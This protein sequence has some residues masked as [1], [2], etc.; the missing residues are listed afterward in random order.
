MKRKDFLKTLSFGTAVLYAPSGLVAQTEKVAPLDKLLVQ[1]FVGAG[2]NNLDKVK[3]LYEEQPALV[4][5]AHDLGGGDFETAIEGAGHVG[6]KEIAQFL[7]EKGARTNLFVL[8]M[9]GK[10]EIVKGFIEAFPAYLTARGPHGFTLLH[11]AQR[12]GED[13]KA[14]LE[15][16][17]MKGLKETRSKL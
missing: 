11:H 9:L 2:H 7:I 13:A 4:Y 15:Y 8:T 10:T 6:N 5:A 3:K 12:G 17:K 14:L 16:L 1:E